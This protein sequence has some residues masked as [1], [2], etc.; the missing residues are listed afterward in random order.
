M[1]MGGSSD[2]RWGSRGES[3]GG[4]EHPEPVVLKVAVAAGGAS[5]E[6]DDAVDGLCAAVG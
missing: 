1:T 5:V 2:I 3:S 4:E 6:L